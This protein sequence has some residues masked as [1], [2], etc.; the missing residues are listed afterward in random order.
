[1]LGSI[2]KEYEVGAN[3]LDFSSIILEY[4]NNV[5]VNIVLS[6][7]SDNYDQ[8]MMIFGTKGKIVMENPYNEGDKPI[9]FPER[10]YNSYIN[11]LET[12]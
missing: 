7:I 12:I 1:M 10:Y 6:R 4:P 3:G 5:E 2:I 8:R 11:E 9:S